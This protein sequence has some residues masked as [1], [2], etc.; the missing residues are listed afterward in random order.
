MSD[1]VG[2]IVFGEDDMNS[3][4]QIMTKRLCKAHRDIIKFIFRSKIWHSDIFEL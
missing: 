4:N 1:S 3:S 2:K